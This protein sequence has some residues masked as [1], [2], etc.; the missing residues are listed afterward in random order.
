MHFNG[1]FLNNVYKYRGVKSTEELSF[2]KLKRD[3]IYEEKLTWG[4][5][6]EKRNLAIFYQSTQKSQNWD[7]DGIF[8]SLSNDLHVL[9]TRQ[10]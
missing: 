7:F 5:E 10:T 2:V 4:L 9:L 8:F 1:L 3:A 6:N